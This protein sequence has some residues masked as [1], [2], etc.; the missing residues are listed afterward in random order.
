[1]GWDSGER[2]RDE[3]AQGGGVGVGVEVRM[4]DGWKGCRG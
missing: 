4:V 2:L 3:D 1:V